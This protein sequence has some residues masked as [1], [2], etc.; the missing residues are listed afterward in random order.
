MNNPDKK[1]YTAYMHKTPENKVY[2]GITSMRLSKRFRNGNGYKT[3][4]L[5]YDAIRKFG[6]KNIEHQT[7]KTGL[8]KQEAEQLEKDL[9]QKY[10]SNDPNYGYN[11]TT[12]GITHTSFNEESKGRMSIARNEFYDSDDGQL[13][14]QKKS[15]YM[16]NKDL[17]PFYG[18][19]HTDEAKKRM[20]NHKKDKKLSKEW[21]ENISKNSFYKNKFGFEH[22]RSKACKCLETNKVYGSLNEAERDTS[23]DSSSISLACRGKRHI[24]GGFHW[25][26]FNEVID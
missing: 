18:K 7:I 17:N 10:K 11:C 8:S 13:L 2:I 1:T 4:A 25:E 12:G 5:F 19:H 22:N 9:I 24:A 14:K 20:S 15:D 26:Y 16:K 21:R 23:I 3:Q 6:W